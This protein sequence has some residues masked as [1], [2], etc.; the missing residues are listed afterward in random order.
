MGSDG[1]AMGPLDG[2]SKSASS[3]ANFYAHGGKRRV[4][5]RSRA[6][7]TV[8]LATFDGKKTMVWAHFPADRPGFLLA[9]GLPDDTQM[10]PSSPLL[11]EGS[12]IA[13]PQEQARKKP[14]DFFVT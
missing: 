1:V 12:K 9:P 3:V 4:S 5:R 13:L 11:P 6:R 2:T 7:K 14:F 8:G 10:P